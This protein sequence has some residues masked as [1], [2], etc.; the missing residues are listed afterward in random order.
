VKRSERFA[1]ISR[2]ADAGVPS[3]EIARRL[4]ISHSYVRDILTDPAGVKTKQRKASYA[5]SCVECGAPTDGANGRAAAPLRCTDCAHEQQHRDRHWTRQRVIEAFTEFAE[6][7]GRS[8]SATD[9]SPALIAGRF[10][11]ERE[12][13]A[14]RAYATGRYPSPTIVARELGSW[15][16]GLAAAGLTPNPTGGAGHM[17]AAKSSAERVAAMFDRELARIE[18][19]SDAL[20]KRL[21]DLREEAKAI[22][23]ARDAFAETQNQREARQQ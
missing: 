21:E 8:P 9:F 5:G 15:R 2:L 4:G 7:N 18:Q 13:E 3:P 19:E 17:S 11:P 22:W 20:E 1:Q 14:V 16:E 6:R 12:A 10:S 23:A